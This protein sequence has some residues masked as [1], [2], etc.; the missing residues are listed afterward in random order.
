MKKILFVS[1][2]ICAFAAAACGSGS[3]KTT[4]I[5]LDET[6]EI[7]ADKMAGPDGAVD[8][9]TPEITYANNNYKPFGVK[10]LNPEY[11]ECSFAYC[12]DSAAKMVRKVEYAEV[13]GERVSYKNNLPIAINDSAA[14]LLRWQV[15]TAALA[16]L[17]FAA[18]LDPWGYIQ[19]LIEAGD[20]TAEIL[21]DALV[22]F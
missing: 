12:V 8:Y 21:A 18:S 20:L 13:N 9:F 16:Q 5:F 14:V 2:V 3:L 15:N 17:N 7:N 22:D 10:I 11:G 6:I 4:V 19:F 1:C